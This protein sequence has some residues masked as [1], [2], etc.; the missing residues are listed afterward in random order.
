MASICAKFHCQAI[1][2]LENTRVGH[3]APQPLP[4]QI[5]YATPDTLNKIGLIEIE[6]YLSNHTLNHSSNHLSNRASNR[7]L[8][9]ALNRLSNCLLN[10]SSELFIESSIESFTVLFNQTYISCFRF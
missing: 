4:S 3:F 7:S 9:Q 1:S 2:S 8:N 10:C 5:K 6:E